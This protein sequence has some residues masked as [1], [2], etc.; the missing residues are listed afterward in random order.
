M[1]LCF[2]AVSAIPIGDALTL[3]YS[4]PLFAMIFSSIFL[5]SR[6]RLY[7]TFLG[8]ILISGIILVVRPP[9]L[10]PKNIIIPSNSSAEHDAHQLNRYEGNDLKIKYI[11]K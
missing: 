10:F 8:T 6:L 5:G 11:L 2:A 9:F 4:N 7:K 3:I 1:I